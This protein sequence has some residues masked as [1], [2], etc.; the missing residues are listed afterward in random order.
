[1]HNYILE[2]V[3]ARHITFHWAISYSSMLQ[4]LDVQQRKILFS[5]ALFA[6]FK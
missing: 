6:T 3:V 1:M 4:E 2:C 5:D